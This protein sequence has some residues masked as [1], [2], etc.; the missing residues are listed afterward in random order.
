V[1]AKHDAKKARGNYWVM[2]QNMAKW[3]GN[4]FWMSKP[5][6]ATLTKK[7]A[8]P[9]PAPSPLDELVDPPSQT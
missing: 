3:K 2:Q 5:K 1:A 9:A 8:E 6:H 7:A 4:Q